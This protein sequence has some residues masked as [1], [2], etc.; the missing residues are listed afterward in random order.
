MTTSRERCSSDLEVG[1]I[2]A[3]GMWGSCKGSVAAFSLLGCGVEGVVL[4]LVWLILDITVVSMCTTYWN[5]TAADARKVY[6]H[7]FLN[8]LSLSLSHTQR[9]FLALN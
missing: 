3:Y 9:Q 2:S 1:N 4:K 6:L 7:S 5:G 8:S